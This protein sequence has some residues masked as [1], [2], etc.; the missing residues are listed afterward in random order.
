MQWVDY[1]S[2]DRFQ[3]IDRFSLNWDREFSYNDPLLVPLLSEM[4][5]PSAQRF[6]KRKE[7]IYVQLSTE[8]ADIA[9]A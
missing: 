7:R 6:Y 3:N 2:S 5:Y 8:Y 4:Y 9:L 1:E